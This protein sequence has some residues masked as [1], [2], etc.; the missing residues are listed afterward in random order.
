MIGYS[1]L[2]ES[3]KLP[4]EEAVR[5]WSSQGIALSPEDFER[6][7]AETGRHALRVSGVSTID[8]MEDVS[9]E[10]ARAIDGEIAFADF[11]K[12]FNEILARRGWEG[13]T[14]WRVETIYRTNLQSAFGA[15]RWAEQ[16]DN[17]A[18]RPWLRYDALDDG[19]A[20]EEHLAMDG[21]VFAIDDPIWR[22]WY[23]PNGYNCRC[24]VEAL[25]DEQARASGKIQTGET[26]RGI[27]PDPGFEH[28]P[29]EGWA[30]DLEKYSPAAQEI[31][32]REGLA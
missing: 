20:R 11:K 5:F 12:S 1:E 15:G 27:Y 25:T 32:N 29:A 31:L 7:W 3:A 16:T 4:F 9:R 18:A 8:A 6:I 24:S 21:R 19:A 26:V 13:M 23:P 2:V 10:I 30:P 17:A 22:T 14:P 28:N